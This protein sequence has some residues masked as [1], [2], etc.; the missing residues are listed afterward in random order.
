MNEAPVRSLAVSVHDVSP[1]TREV[2]EVM[3]ADL[4]AAGVGVTS[5]LVVPDHHHRADID[6]DPGFLAWLRA[7]EAAGHEIVLHGFYHRREAA[8]GGGLARKIVTEHY[9]AG[10]GEF[11]D[12]G[13][14]EA[15]ERMA[16]GREM[17]TAAGLEVVGFIAP[18]WLLG[19]EAERAAKNLG[20]A[21]TTRLG[22]VR[23]LRSGAWTASQSLVWSVRSGWRRVVSR[24]WNAWLA[25]RL[26]RNPLAR[27]GLHPP[28]W[29]YDKIR[30]QALRLA[31][32]ATVDRKVIR[33][34]EWVGA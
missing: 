11:Y 9:T 33:Y 8:A 23:D 30:A 4:A 16:K 34:R 19:D 6:Q 15:R 2:V 17:L 12:L 26:R 20:F 7:K 1:L 25:A 27:L 13:Y 28:D 32:E 29:R 31:R 5:L 18:A 14:E 22:G 3:L 24:G 21:Y 10:E